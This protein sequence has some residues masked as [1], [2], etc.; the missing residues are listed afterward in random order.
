M[1]QGGI[2]GWLIGNGLLV[3][4]SFNTIAMYL[5]SFHRLSMTFVQKWMTHWKRKK[6]SQAL[7]LFVPD[8]Q[9]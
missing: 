9:F 3:K 5:N 4:E 2:L 6:C 8:V 7:I 1:G